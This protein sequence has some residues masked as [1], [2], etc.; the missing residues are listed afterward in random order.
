MSW[1][2]DIQEKIMSEL[3]GFFKF[4]TTE[5]KELKIYNIWWTGFGPTLKIAK[6]DMPADVWEKLEESVTRKARE[7]ALV[8]FKEVLSSYMGR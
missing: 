1:Y 5:D 3:A 7:D 8:S 2:E 4:R 6:H